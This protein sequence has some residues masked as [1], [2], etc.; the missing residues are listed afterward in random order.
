MGFLR[1]LVYKI[2]YNLFMTLI[3]L[4]GPKT[5]LFLDLFELKN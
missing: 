4:N 2:E 1:L 5:K 3:A